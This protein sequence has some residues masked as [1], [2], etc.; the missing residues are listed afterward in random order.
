MSTVIFNNAFKTMTPL[1][2]AVVTTVMTAN[3]DY[4]YE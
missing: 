4:R 2:D 1:I 3:K